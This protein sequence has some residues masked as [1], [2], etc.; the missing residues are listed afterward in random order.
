MPQRDAGYFTMDVR[1]KHHAV[2]HEGRTLVW[3]ELEPEQGRF[4]FAEVHALLARAAR[5]GRGVVL[6]LKSSVVR[7]R[8]VWGPLEA[9]PAWVLEQHRPPVGRIRDR[10][11]RD[12]IEIVPPWHPGVQADYLRFVEA[13]GR[14]HFDRYPSLLGLYVHGISSSFGEEMW[15]DREGFEAMVELGMTPERLENAMSARIRAWAEALSARPALLGW[16]GAGWIDATGDP[17][18][19]RRVRERLDALALGLGL[20]RRWGNIESYNGGTEKNGQHLQADGRLRTDSA[21]PLIAERR[22]WAAENENYDAPSKADAFAYRMA[23]LRALQMRLRLLWVT[24]RALVLGPEISHY[25]A[26]VAGLEPRRSPDA[27]VVLGEE[28]LR[29]GRKQLRMGNLEHGVVQVEPSSGARSVRSLPV[30]RPPQARDW[31]EPVDWTARRTNRAAG[32]DRLVFRLDEE[33]FP[34]AEG[35]PRTLQVTWQDE[36]QDWHVELRTEAGL[37]RSPSGG[38]G[39][40]GI[41]RTTTFAL[42]AEVGRR[43][44][45]ER[46]DLAVVT[47]ERDIAIKRIRLLRAAHRTT[48]PECGGSS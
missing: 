23:T 14:E 48:S 25:F 5:E 8:S 20:G 1:S 36:G 3:S 29:R 11:P 35:W 40:G 43:P 33:F 7:R 39:G 6:R 42:P 12:F 38:E 26:R 34:K 13:F 37:L 22:F 27:W 44:D 2:V 19:W 46:G 10:G 18:E 45:A 16:V 41:E 9:V 17:S 32:V 21:H 24:D 28:E 47:G 31:Q 15:M 4:E 30:E